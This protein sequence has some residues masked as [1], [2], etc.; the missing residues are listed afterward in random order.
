MFQFLIKLKVVVIHL[1]CFEFVHKY[2]LLKLLF[3]ETNMIL[4][5][6]YELTFSSDIKND[7]T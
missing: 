4:N 3:H 7:L 6:K 5:L 2:F 1:A